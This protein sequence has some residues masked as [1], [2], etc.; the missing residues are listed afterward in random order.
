MSDTSDLEKKVIAIIAKTLS[1]DANKV[2]L[3]SNFTNDLS[4]DSLDLV[5]LIMNIEATFDIEIPDN[6]ASTLANVKQVVD[7]IQQK[8]T[9]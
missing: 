1:Q 2:T 5:E 6:Q 4:A 7:Y 8:V 3:E 9:A